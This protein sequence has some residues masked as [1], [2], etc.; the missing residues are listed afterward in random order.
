MV[1]QPPG[2]RLFSKAGLM[3]R[4]EM[5]LGKPLAITPP[6]HKRK[7]FNDRIR[8]VIRSE[9][10]EKAAANDFETFEEANDFDIEDDDFWDPETPYE[11]VFEPEPDPADDFADKL[12]QRIAE[13]VK[14]TSEGNPPTEE[15]NTPQIAAETLPEEVK[16]L[17]PESSP[18]DALRAL[19][20]LRNALGR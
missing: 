19:S 5:N 11:E 17:T 16:Q 2:S 18:E 6:K 1:G 3:S 20:A 7:S 13:A 9:L 14:P 10:S 12:A 8:E 15:G 4:K